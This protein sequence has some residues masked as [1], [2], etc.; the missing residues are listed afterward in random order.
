MPRHFHRHWRFRRK[1]SLSF[2]DRHHCDAVDQA[3]RQNELA[4]TSDRS[5]AHN[6]AA[7]RNWPSLEFFGRRI[8]AHDHIRGWVRLAIPDDAVDNR[9]AIGLGLRTAWRRPPS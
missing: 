5:V 9:D 4:V 2:L 6:I 7:A 8:E 1:A 3:V